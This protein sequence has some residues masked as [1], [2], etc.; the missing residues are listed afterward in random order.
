[1]NED[2]ITQPDAEDSYNLSGFLFVGI[3]GFTYTCLAFT[4]LYYVNQLG[5]VA[6]ELLCKHV[7]LIL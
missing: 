3:M 2:A 5:N 7:A 4:L 6:V 1:M